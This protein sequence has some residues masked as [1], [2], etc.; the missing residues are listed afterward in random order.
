MEN[1]ARNPEK[2]LGKFQARGIAFEIDVFRLHNRIIVMP[3][4]APQYFLIGFPTRY[5]SSWSK[6]QLLIPVS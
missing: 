2:I 3:I 6:P 4:W 5:A 1:Q